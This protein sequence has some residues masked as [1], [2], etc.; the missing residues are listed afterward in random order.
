MII[1]WTVLSQATVFLGVTG[2]KHSFIPAM[3]DKTIYPTVIFS[4]LVQYLTPGVILLDIKTKSVF[5]LIFFS[6]NFSEERF[7][8][9]SLSLLVIAPQ[10][11]SS[12]QVEAKK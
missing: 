6:E 8:T 1:V 7:A 12:G 2:T 3:Q 5:V 9:L 11:W 10:E 4:L